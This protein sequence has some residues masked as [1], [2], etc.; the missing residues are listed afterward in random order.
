MVVQQSW[1]DASAPLGQ[2]VAEQTQ[3]MLDAYQANPDLV[4][5]H[6]NIEAAISQ[7][8]Y[9]RKQLNE[10][11]QNAADAIKTPGGRISVVLTHDALYCANEGQPLTDEGVKTLMLSHSSAKRDN[12]IGK[13]GLGF[14]SVIQITDTPSIFSRSCSISWSQ[15]RNRNILETIFSGL[16]IYPTLRIANP[17]DPYRASDEDP[18]LGELMAWASTVVK[19]PLSSRLKWL[20]EEMAAF[21]KE[22]LLFSRNVA[23]LELDDRVENRA[24]SWTA[25]RDDQKVVISNGVSNSEWVVFEHEHPV[26]TMA[27]AEAGS[28]AARPTVTVTWAVPLSSAE[29]KKQRLGRFWNY[30]PTKHRTSLSG[31]VNAAFKMNEDRYSMLETLYNEEILKT[32]LPI[33]VAGALEHLSPT[34]DPGLFLDILPS[35]PKEFESWADKAINE[36]IFAILPTVPSLPDRS[37]KLQFPQ[38]I[39]VQPVLEDADRLTKLWESWIPKE[40]PWLHSSALNSRDREPQVVRILKSANLKRTSLEEWL[41]EVVKGGEL[42]DYENALQLAAMIDKSYSAYQAEMRRSRIILMAD[43]SNQP[44]LVSRVFLPLD[45]NDESDNVVS[46]DLM[47][48]GQA[49]SYLRALDLQAQDGRGTVSRVA[50]AAAQDYADATLAESLWK[51]TRTLPMVESLTIV[52]ERTEPLQLLVR[53]RDS[54]WRP[55][56][57]VWLPGELMS[58]SSVG[59]EH[60]LIDAQRHNHD[61]ALLRNLGA[62]TALSEPVMTSSGRTFDEWKTAQAQRISLSSKSGPAPI[63]PA[64]IRFS[65]TLVTDGLHL[66]LDASA[67]TRAKVTNLLLDRPQ[68]AADVR[69]TS[70]YRS[71]EKINGPDIWWVNNYGVLQTPIGLVDV[72][73]CVSSIEGIPTGFLPY[74]GDAVATTLNLP[75]DATKVKWQMVLAEA[76]KVLS[77]SDVH[78]LYGALA[79]LGIKPPKELLVYLGK[80]RTTR[81]LIEH[82]ILAADTES[83]DYL[84]DIADQAVLYTGEPELDSSLIDQWGIPMQ[85]VDFFTEVEF[86]AAESD[87]EDLTIA[88]HYPFLKRAASEVSVSTRCVPCSSVSEV[89]TNTF[90]SRRNQTSRSFILSDGSLYYRAPQGEQALLTTVLAAFGSKRDTIKVMQAMRQLKKDKEIQDRIDKAG[91]HPTD[92]G[93]IAE[94]V[95]RQTLRN[96]IPD[97]VVRM[98]EARGLELT[99]ERLFEVVSN[100]HGQGLLKV[101]KPALEEAGIVVPTQFSGGRTAQEFVEELGFSPAMAGRTTKKKPAREEVVGPVGLNPLHD[102]QESTS[103]KIGKLLAGSTE[104]SRGLVQ[105]PTGAGKTRVAVESVIRDVKTAPKDKRRLEIGRAHV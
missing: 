94:L 8:G 24:V 91:K 79:K 101:L 7:G 11:V 20:S 83:R 104:H 99:D 12:E 103:Q 45:P 95:G 26:T 71:A 25:Q 98:L 105:L 77:V 54:K 28:L 57:D 4:R 66:L 73:N 6:S 88:Q 92:A 89:R 44:A 31:I 81:E 36:P 80:D 82:V 21:P 60:L 17:V 93:K 13:F 52:R 47:Q 62:R 65:P 56:G 16:D 68:Y 43:G 78:Q 49:I 72:K 27:A 33:M 75:T 59:D 1:A 5:E 42:Q 87:A 18:V 100:L 46:Y 32:A 53:C 90:D 84:V 3:S 30:F 35:R 38:D 41:E 9:G 102:Y 63:S 74:P 2:F 58:A 51:L 10:L 67:T 34:T 64:G 96:L 61:L 86:S 37:G 22:F 29:Q 48:Q 97:A 76:E 85:K 15:E 39:K 23:R 40:R 70:T 69:F 19:L 14:K 50:A 55:L